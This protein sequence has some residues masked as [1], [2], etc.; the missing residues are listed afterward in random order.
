MSQDSTGIVT[1]ER[2]VTASLWAER[3]HTGLESFLIMIVMIV[4]R[5][6]ESSHPPEVHTDHLTLV[7]G[8]QQSVRVE[9]VPDHSLHLAAWART[10]L[11]V[12]PH[13]PAVNHSDRV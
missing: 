2:P 8:C 9:M 10:P 11:L 12:L 4:I 13:C 6:H 7:S 3:V 1:R 5:G